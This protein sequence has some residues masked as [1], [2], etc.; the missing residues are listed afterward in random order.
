M[1]EK[2]HVADKLEELGQRE[3]VICVTHAPSIAAR[4][5]KNFF[6]KKYVENDMTETHVIPLDTEDAIVKEI[7]RM[8]GSQDDWQQEHAKRQ[9]DMKRDK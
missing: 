3:Q 4:G 9:R 6:I 2:K 8:S 5:D 7:A 1:I